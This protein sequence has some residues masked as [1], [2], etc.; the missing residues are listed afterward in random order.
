ME[1]L[2][3]FS[4]DENIVSYFTDFMTEYQ[5]LILGDQDDDTLFFLNPKTGKNELYVH[6]KLNDVEHEFTYN[7][8]NDESSFIK[9]FFRGERS[10]FSFDIQYHDEEIL[11]ELLKGFKLYIKSKNQSERK[12]MILLSH[13]RQGV[14]DIVDV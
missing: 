8:S 12:V 6:F 3:F 4:D 14:I 5:K 7:Y 13:P 11:K 10:I 9:S 2:S 1:V